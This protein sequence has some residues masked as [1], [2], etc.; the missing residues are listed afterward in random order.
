MGRFV[1][2][3]DLADGHNSI[4]IPQGSTAE[5]PVNPESGAIRFNTSINKFEYYNGIAWVALTGGVSGS[6]SITTDSITITDAGGSVPDATYTMSTSVPS[7]E[8]NKI[9]VF[10]A[11]VYQAPSKYTVSGTDITFSGLQSID[12]GETI[13]ILHGFDAA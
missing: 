11:G 12:I 4:S 2:Y 1:K 5:A 13:T 9:F 8:E 7:N 3:F 10:I 6:L